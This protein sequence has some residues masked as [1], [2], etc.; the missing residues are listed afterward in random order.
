MSSASASS[1]NTYG[2]HHHITIFSPEGRLFQVEYAFKAVTAEGIT[3]LAIKGN[4]CAVLVVNKKIPDKMHEPG[5]L[6]HLH[7]ITQ[8]IGAMAIGMQADSRALV[9][10]ARQEAADYRHK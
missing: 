4:D 7:H 1:R 2:Y 3:G 9:A 8:G 5:T 10:R 6:G